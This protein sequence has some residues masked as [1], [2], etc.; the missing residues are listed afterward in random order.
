MGFVAS[1]RTPHTMRLGCLLLASAPLSC[2]K[3]LSFVVQV[4]SDARADCYSKVPESEVPWLEWDT[5][6]PPPEVVFLSSLRS[7]QCP[8]LFAVAMLNCP[9][10]RVRLRP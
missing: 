8:Q 9:Q 10:S 3:D 5:G 4:K 1:A 7:N 2:S 6:A